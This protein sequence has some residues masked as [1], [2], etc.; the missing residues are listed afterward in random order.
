MSWIQV[1]VIVVV[2]G[3]LLWLAVG[4]LSRIREVLVEIRDTLE[5][6][7]IE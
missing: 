4:E 3:G 2:L 7:E 6:D 5:E 1:A